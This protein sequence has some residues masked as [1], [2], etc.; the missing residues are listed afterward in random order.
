MISREYDESS[1]RWAVMHKDWPTMMSSVDQQKMNIEDWEECCSSVE[2]IDE[3]MMMSRDG[4]AA[5]WWQ[6]VIGIKLASSDLHLRIGLLK[7]FLV[8][9][10]KTRLGPVSKLVLFLSIG[11]DRNHEDC[12]LPCTINKDQFSK[13]FC[14]SWCDDCMVDLVDAFNYVIHDIMIDIF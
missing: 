3:Q 14:V 5:D 13:Y 9:A 6:F 12:C 7:P 11:A 4:W 2:Q 1:C 10:K 8:G